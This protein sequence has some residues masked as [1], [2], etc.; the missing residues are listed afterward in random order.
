[1]DKKGLVIISTIENNVKKIKF[2]CSEQGCSEH[3]I[4]SHLLQKNGVLNTIS[5]NGH[6]IQLRT[7]KCFF[8]S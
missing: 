6:L 8:L 3:A 7:K 4:N 2:K 5:D 1:M